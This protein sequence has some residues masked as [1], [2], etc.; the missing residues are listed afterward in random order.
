MTKCV[1]VIRRTHQHSEQ[2]P[3]INRHS[4]W[5]GPVREVWHFHHV[6]FFILALHLPTPNVWLESFSEV[7]R[8]HDSVDD[9]DDDQNNG[10]DSKCCKR[11]SD[12]EVMSGSFGMLVHS[13]K[14]EHKIG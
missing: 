12:R 2:F 10:D 6:W 7:D 3:L 8:A 5:Y 4:A 14:L 11:F 13:H 1:P 9:C